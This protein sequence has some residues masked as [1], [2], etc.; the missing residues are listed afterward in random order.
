MTITSP[1]KVIGRYFFKGM[2][3]SEDVISLYEKLRDH[4][5]SYADGLDF[6]GSIKIN[7]I[8]NELYEIIIEPKGWR[9]HS[10]V[11]SNGLDLAVGAIGGAKEGVAWGVDLP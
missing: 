6:S 2:E 4:L 11:E 9:E 10:I 1:P 5:Q 3:T 8:Q 7:K